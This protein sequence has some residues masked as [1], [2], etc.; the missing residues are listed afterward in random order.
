MHGRI[1]VF[2]I[3]L[4][5]NTGV[6][7]SF[8]QNLYVRNPAQRLIDKLVNITHNLFFKTMATLCAVRLLRLSFLVLLIGS[9]TTACKKSGGTDDV[10]PRDQ[11]VGTYVGSDKAYQS[12]ITVGT[13][14]F[15]PEYGTTNLTVSKGSNP[16]EIYIED[17]KLSLKVTAELD[18]VNFT[19]TDKNSG[20]IFV[21]PSNTYTGPYTAT[22]VLGKEQASGKNVI[23]LT[24]VTEALKNGTT[25]RKVETFNGT[26]N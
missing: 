9:L 20:Q 8:G 4:G 1:I 17:S 7:C 13:I 11:Y 3:N 21:P 23:V 15:N 6:C 16:K 10:D 5:T 2:D 24:A 14:P 26:R 25:I 18:G 19:V 12:V 22:G